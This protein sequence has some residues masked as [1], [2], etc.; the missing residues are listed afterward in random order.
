MELNKKILHIGFLLIGISLVFTITFVSVYKLENPVFLKMFI[1]KSIYP[2]EDFALLESFELKYIT[3]ISDNRKI[4]NMEFKE[5]PDIEVTVSN[6]SLGYGDM[7]FFNDI[8]KQSENKYGIYVVNTIYFNMN[9]KNI[10]KKLNEIE[11]NNVKITFNDGSRLNANLGRII[12]HKDKRNFKDIDHIGSSGSS[13]GEFSSERRLKKN[14]KLLKVDT[15]LL[16]CIK[17]CFNISID[18]IDY[19]NISGTKY[20]KDKV[21]SIYSR[22]KA[23]KSIFEKYS[24]Y[25]IDPKLYY[26]DNKGNR[27]YTSIDNISHMPDSFDFIGIF[28]YLKLMGV[29]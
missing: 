16:N 21:L 5:K 19:K 27:S 10:D 2:D 17:D 22:F 24:Y 15:P 8:N 20:E 11:L 9:L 7:P 18:N 3:S 25:D 26:E 23:P 14:I 1:Q 28:K 6:D 13:D 4:V 12:L 29:I